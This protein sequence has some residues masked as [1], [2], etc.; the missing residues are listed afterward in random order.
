[1]RTHGSASELETRR[2]R[3][4]KL[5]GQG[6]GYRQV[7]A[8]LGCSPRS[9]HR[10]QAAY[11]EAGKDALAAKPHPGAPPRLSNAQKAD[12]V[13]R[14]LTGA[15][16]QG[17]ATDLWTSKRILDLIQRRYR[18]TYHVN[19]ISQLLHSLGFS[20]QKPQRIAAERD[21][22]AIQHWIDH[23]WP[24]IKKRRSGGGPR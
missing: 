8:K 19:Y 18:V 22:K 7:A 11:E 21:E 4:I 16:A 15:R 12:L 1:M 2:K 6:W 5:L 9:V 3:A 20:C 23:D 17:F 24:R 14:L 10:W 13:K